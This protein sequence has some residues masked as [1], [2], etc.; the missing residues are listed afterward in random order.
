MKKYL[1]PSALILVGFLGFAL[2][3]NITKSVQLSQSAQGPIGMDSSNNVFFPAHILNVGRVPTVSSPAGTAPTIATGSTD[4]MGQVT[5][6]S[7]GNTTGSITFNV[8][9]GA[10]PVCILTQTNGTASTPTWTTATTGINITNATW[11]IASYAYI[12]SGAQ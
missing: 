1:L 11:G 9:Y 6:G 12:C 8:A 3:Q 2:A 10:A 5:G 4:W 7:V